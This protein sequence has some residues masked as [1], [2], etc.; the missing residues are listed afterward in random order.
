MSTRVTLPS[1]GRGT[2]CYG[3]EFADGTKTPKAKPGTSVE[4]DDH[5]YRAIKNGAA[6]RSGLITA[7]GYSFGTKGTM[8]CPACGRRWNAWTTECSCGTATV[9][10]EAAA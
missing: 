3:L 5:R 8:V 2:G 6:G 7:T 9:P 4:I 1:N 10:A